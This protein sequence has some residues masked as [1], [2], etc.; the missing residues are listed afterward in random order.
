M[1]PTV[2]Y[3]PEPKPR[4]RVSVEVKDGK[5]VYLVSFHPRYSEITQY[6]LSGLQYLIQTA[7]ATDQPL[8]A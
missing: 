8:K 3:W 2:F 7:Y 1:K 6:S 4:F 5:Q